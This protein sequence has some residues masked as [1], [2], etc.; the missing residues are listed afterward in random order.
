MKKRL[1]LLIS[2]ILFIALAASSTYWGMELS[3][4]KARPVAAPPP[5]Q[6]AEVPVENAATL[7]G[8]KLAVAT[9]SNFQVKGVIS[10]KSGHGGTAVI[11]AEGQP[12]QTLGVG[13]EVAPGVSVKE[14]HAQ[15][16][17][18][19]DNG[20]QK[21]LAVPEAKPGAPNEGILPMQPDPNA[22]RMTGPALPQPLPPQPVTI[23]VEPPQ[24]PQPPVSPQQIQAPQATPQPG[25]PPVP[26][27]P[28]GAGLGPNGEPLGMPATRHNK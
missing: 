6:Q 17:L 5:P 18:L 3:K 26:P 23:P 14:I 9:A 15:Y 10:S 1:P 21:R 11:L 24:P 20:V 19:L 22:S 27:Q 4:Q 13:S 16:V 25:Q 7:F 8:G 12:A 2:F 28:G